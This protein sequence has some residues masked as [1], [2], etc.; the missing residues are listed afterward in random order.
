M[1]RTAQERLYD[2][3]LD[4]YGR[5][6]A[7]AFLEAIADITREV[8]IDRLIAAIASGRVDDAIAAM[9]IDAAAFGPLE[10][11]L[12]GSYIAAGQGYSG[13]IQ[14]AS[15]LAAV[16][17]FNGRN[18]GAEAWLREESSALV[19]RVV[20]EQV[21]AL[22]V[23][24]TE[25]LAAGRHPTST[26]LDIVGR[27][28]PVTKVR[29]GGIVG[30]SGPQE[31]WARTALAELRSGDPDA[32]AHYL[33]RER[34]DKRYD[35][36]VRRAIRDGRA[37][38]AEWVDKA[39]IAYRNRLLKLRGDMIG[40]TESM[41]AIQAAKRESF[42]QAIETGGFLDSEIERIWR[43]SSDFRVRHT[44]AILDGQKRQGMA[45]PFASVSGALLMYPGDPNAPAAERI[46]CRCDLE[47]RLDFIARLRRQEAGGG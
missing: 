20:R 43:D 5:R 10:E 29:E 32:M 2:E 8:D 41:S 33:T 7:D 23:A 15:N 42:R 38:E 36:A 34:R 45:A 39:S 12:R 6:V 21:E 22:R 25:G 31:V 24:L 46:A 14:S 17:R 3:L 4:R 40:R 30:L 37:L 13:L 47:Y 35:A 28:N 19:T 16:F 18:P 27:I 1:A 11:A 44:H 9:H 26:A